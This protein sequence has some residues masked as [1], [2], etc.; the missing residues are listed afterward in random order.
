MDNRLV[1]T[2]C[3]PKSSCVREPQ[4]VYPTNQ[5]AQWVGRQKVGVPGNDFQTMG[6]RGLASL[7]W[8]RAGLNVQQTPRM[9]QWYCCTASQY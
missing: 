3:I 9:V 4:D 7:L 1:P 2:N 6:P 5:R 8:D